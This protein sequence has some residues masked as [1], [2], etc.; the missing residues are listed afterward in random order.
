MKKLT[1]PLAALL[2]GLLV[3]A[4]CADKAAATP[5]PKVDLDFER[6]VSVTGEL[7]PAR[8]ATV[9]TKVGGR[10]V[11]V[12]V[13]PG[14]SVRVGTILVRLDTTDL[15]LALHVAQ[16]EMVAQQAV[17]DQLLAGS[18]Q[19]MIDRADRENAQRIEQAEVVVRIKERQ[20]EQARAQDPAKD[21]AAAQAQV[22]QLLAQVAQAQAQN[23]QAQVRIAQIELER[24]QIAQDDA[25]DEYQQALDR[26]WEKQKVRD[27]LA[28]VLEQAQLSHRAAQARLDDAQ[29]ALQAHTASL[30]VLAAQVTAARIRLEQAQDA[31]RV[32]RLGL[33]IL[34]D[35]VENARLALAHLGAWENPYRDPARAQE[36][37]QAEARLEQ[38]R[39][40]VAQIEQQIQ[41]ATVLSPLEGTVGLVNVRAGE[42]VV[43]VQPLAVVGDLDTLR[44]ETTDLDEIDI[45]RVSVGQTAAVVFDALPDRVFESYVTRISPMAEPGSGGVHYSVVLDLAEVDPVLRWGM[46]AFVDIAAGGDN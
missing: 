21:V 32:H 26:P 10:V 46:T 36:I 29:S 39:G 7:V 45:V 16:Q 43:P 40:S 28:K 14:A 15:E 38:A 41:D 13:E 22:D 11:E 30:R 20:L 6:V 4:G 8:W 19:P 1:L 17:L 5:P 44:V 9:S 33:S 31:Q 42:Q 35:E 3:L 2:V 37:E 25:Q 18:S 27:A 23:P 34:E 24:A 12:L